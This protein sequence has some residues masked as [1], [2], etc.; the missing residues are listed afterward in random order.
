MFW[1]DK[2]HFIERYFINN[3]NNNNKNTT[4]TTTTNNNINNNRSWQC[5]VDLQ[6][7]CRDII[8]SIVETYIFRCVLSANS[9]RPVAE[10]IQYGDT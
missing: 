1:L 7:T 2:V 3:N 8:I 5:A 10:H 4:T 9:L 6:P